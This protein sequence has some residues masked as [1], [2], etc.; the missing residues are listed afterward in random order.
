MS[1]PENVC[2][3]ECKTDQLI[4]ATQETMQQLRPNLPASPQEYL[5]I[6]KALQNN[7]GYTLLLLQNH[8]QHCC[9]V[10]G[11]EI[12]QRLATG[13]TL[14][15]ADLVTDQAQ[16]SRGYGA[17]LLEFIYKKAQKLNLDGVTLDSGLA[18]ENAHRFYEREG[19]AKKAYHF[20]KQ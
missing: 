17:H 10:A 18:R 5:G 13:N 15:I 4:I 12:T 2:I 19:F 3:I 11:Y 16:R 6:I 20:I 9:A 14:Y 7:K 8:Q 1:E